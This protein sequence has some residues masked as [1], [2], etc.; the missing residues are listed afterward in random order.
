MDP[1]NFINFGG[2]EIPA[3]DMESARI[4]VL[5]V[6]YENAPS[7]GTGSKMGSYHILNASVQLER[8]DE[9][10]LIDWGLLKIN[11]A[12]ALTPADDPEKAVSEIKAAAAHILSQDRFLLALGGDHAISIGLIL[13]AAMIYPD[14]G[15]LQIDAHL[16][17]RDQWNG[18]SFNHACVMR[19]ISEKLNSPII[20]VGIR[21]F[22]PEE[23]EVRKRKNFTTFF[24]HQIDAHDTGWMDRVVAALP[25]QV[26]I[27]IDLDG[28]DPSVIPATGTPEPG[29]LSYRQLVRLLEKVGRNRKVIA[30][31][32]NE[33]THIDGTYL[34]EFTAA[35]LATK[36]FVYCV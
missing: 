27:T 34:S 9:E 31:D 3:S 36:I 17:L 2:D 24:A 25:E 28:L 22:S 1:N 7:Y 12:P 26:Y 15:V 11:T 29:G 19:R 30:A 20:Q 18:S 8:M 23:A 10:T 4:V 16:D 21:S 35:K 32:I 5:P 14:M 13:G 33:L 6:C